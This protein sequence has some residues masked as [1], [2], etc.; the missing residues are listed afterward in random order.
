M[1]EVAGF[2]SLMKA[3]GQ[4]LQATEHFVAHACQTAQ[5]NLNRPIILRCGKQGLEGVREQDGDDQGAQLCQLFLWQP[6]GE[7]ERKMFSAQ[8]AIDDQR[9]RPGF[10][11]IETDADEQDQEHQNNA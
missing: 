7:P 2:G 5:P 9:H 3:Q 4:P 1:N 11:Q 10:E 8:H 6:L